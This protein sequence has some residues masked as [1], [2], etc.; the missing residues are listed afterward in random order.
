MLKL[1]TPLIVAGA[2]CLLSMLIGMINGVRFLNMLLR[3]LIAGI[4]AGGFVFCARTLLQKFVPDL[5][6]PPTLSDTAAAVTAEVPSGANVNITLDD[7]VET[8]AVPDAAAAEHID[9]AGTVPD[10][11]DHPET[12]TVM[13][14][15]PPDSKPDAS[16]DSGSDSQENFKVSTSPPVSSEGTAQEGGHLSD[17]PN[18]GSFMEPDNDTD[19]NA[20][21]GLE[22]DSS[23]FSMNGIQSSGTDDSKVMAQAIRTVL[24][25]DD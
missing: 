24:A 16:D 12:H 9:T 1:K 19:E 7:D 13:E 18:M 3:G 11:G 17:L 5:F 15:N 8:A 6:M 14:E 10:A 21:T 4:A 23:G 20:D 2:M 22:A 25:S